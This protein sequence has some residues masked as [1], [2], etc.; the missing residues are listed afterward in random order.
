MIRSQFKSSIRIPLFLMLGRKSKL[1]IKK[2]KE[3]FWVTQL[4]LRSRAFIPDPRAKLIVSLTSFPARIN[5]AWIA[6]ESI[7]QQDLRPSKVVLVLSDE[8]F[9]TRELPKRIQHQVERGLEI[10]WTPRDTRGYKKLLPARERYPDATIVTVDDDILFE[11][12]RLR[13]LVEAA[14]VRRGAI[15]GHRGWVVTKT[16]NGL[17]PY[18]SW[19]I[20]GP[21]TP[22]E[23]TFLTSGAGTLFPPHVLPMDELLNIDLLLELCPLAD[24]IWFWAV[25][26]TAGV[27]CYCLGNHGLR[28]V[29]RLKRTPALYHSNWGEAQNDVQLA[30]VIAHFGLAGFSK[31]G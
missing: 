25:A 1:G 21:E 9:P 19:P 14:K 5:H 31:N 17:A 2:I 6:I 12:W 4:R 22:A 30:A 16:H 15:I 29:Q 11:P 20:A 7:F 18:V 27:E 8:E 28:S 24:D 26:R 3:M 13:Q 10:L 23:L